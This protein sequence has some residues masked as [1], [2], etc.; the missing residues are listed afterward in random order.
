MFDLKLIKVAFCILLVLILTISLVGCFSGGKIKVDK[1]GNVIIK[2]KDDDG[3]GVVIGEKKWNKSKMYGLDAPKAKLETSL[4]SEDGSM[5]GFSGMKEKDAKEYIE[6]IKSAG[7]TY[8]SATFEDYIFS[9][10]NKEG[11]TVTFSYDKENE[12]GS[13]MCG[14]GEPPSD[15]DNGDGAVVGGAGKKW[16][17]EKMGGLP[18]PGVKVVAYW[19][20]GDTTNYS[21]EVIPSFAGY[22]EKIKAHG[23]TKDIDEAE[24]DNLYVYAASNNAGDRVT[25]S[26]GADMST[27][28]FEKQN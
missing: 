22:I 9:G 4:I 23:F 26:S 20:T 19:T 10:T 17:S 15:E 1:D 25:L 7:F 11:L 3:N 5:Y 12:S 18:D 24:I 6:K 14:T 2:D 28:I 13:I 27:I 16:D 21:L 8:N